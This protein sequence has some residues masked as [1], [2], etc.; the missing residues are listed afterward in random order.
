MTVTTIPQL[1]LRELSEAEF[2][3]RYS[4]DRF[5]AT[6]LSNRFNYIMEHLCGALL[7]TAFSAILR[8]WY[9]F[10]AT[11]AGPP[12]L[13]YLTPALSNSL[14]YHAGTMMDAVR[15]TVEEFGI[16]RLD[17]GDVVIGNDPYRTGTHVNDLL[18]VRPV[19]HDD[20]ILGFISITAHQLDMGGV[21]PGGFSGTKRSV[22]ENGLVISPRRLLHRDK[23]VA[24]TFSLI[25]DN[26][27]FGGVIEPDLKN[28]DAALRLGERLL[29]ETTERY[30]APALLGAMRYACDASAERMVES[31]VALPDGTYEGED[32][33][34]ADGIDDSE[35]Y[36]VKVR[37]IKRGG[38]AEVDV[39]GSSRQM[40]TSIN[41]SVL[42]AK[43]TVIV[44]MKYLFDPRGP[45]TSGA[46]RSIDLIIPEGTML[47]ALPPDGAVFLYWEATNALLSA[48]FRAL[49]PVMGRGAIAGDVS[50]CNIH[51]A[52]GVLPDGTPWLSGAQCGGE[53]G[54][55]GAT[56]HGDAES[57]MSVYQAN[58]L[59]PALESIEA[60]LPIAIMRREPVIDSGG[61]GIN[62]GGA[63]VLK[64]S[65]WMSPADHYSMP[66]RF[67]NRS[68]FGVYGGAAGAS[69]GVWMWDGAEA[70]P[71]QRP[72]DEGA[73]GDAIPIAG[74][75]D[76]I[77]NAPSAGGRYVYFAS[78]PVRHTE[79][80]ATWRYITN[81]GG[82][83][84]SPLQ[85]DPSRVLVDVRDGYVSL[86]GARNDYGVVI[87]GDPDIDPE[88][89]RLDLDA[90][91][92]LRGQLQD[93]TNTRSG[94]A[95][96]D[97]VD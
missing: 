1:A 43:T 46:M 96:D 14:V 61:P 92:R 18:L 2:E 70:A 95:P 4:C 78:E 69:G 9:D 21:V 63:A 47:S 8:D 90:T 77:S 30:G 97:A 27:R 50:S 57:Y 87:A 11:L 22:F 54:P 33:V 35:E 34:D 25:L 85:R 88:G 49:S 41:A 12:S 72:V 68:G 42:D 53:H 20:E 84:G 89:L 64:D 76:P 59:D 28:V 62:R 71:P 17:P 66:L 94:A 7:T 56:R 26:V 38:R 6:V 5:T 58:G 44:A 55:W 45:F 81:G 3:Q 31:L 10:A 39:S 36:R 15:N 24:E 80:L 65:L 29:I 86:E 82:G 23:R 40:R 51:N 16:D 52:N 73:Y 32:V 74:C 19:F 75:L 13:D 79:P 37:I 91:A 67:K 93:E 60:D 48:I 83:W